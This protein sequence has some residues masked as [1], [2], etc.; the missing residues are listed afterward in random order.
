MQQSPAA[1]CAVHVASSTTH[2]A[3]PHTA[4]L[5]GTQRPSGEQVV[6]AQQSELVT[7]RPPQQGGGEQRTAAHSDRSMAGAGSVPLLLHAGPSSHANP[8]VETTH[9]A[10]ARASRPRGEGLGGTRAAQ[11]GQ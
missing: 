9:S 2:F 4:Q 11:L 10:R 3:S 6:A 8:R 7:Q 1:H 5:C